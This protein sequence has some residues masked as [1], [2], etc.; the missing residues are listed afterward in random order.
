M[1]HL[2]V[3]CHRLSF[4]TRNE[5][6]SYRLSVLRLHTYSGFSI[7]TLHQ[8]YRLQYAFKILPNNR[9]VCFTYRHPTVRSKSR[10]LE[11]DSAM[12]VYP[13]ISSYN[14]LQFKTVLVFRARPTTMHRACHCLSKHSH[15]AQGLALLRV[16]NVT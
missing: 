16:C 11:E 10:N 3:V 8:A 1:G 7:V 6:Y 5:S 14:S 4:F 2:V 15:F 12:C 13:D 9:F